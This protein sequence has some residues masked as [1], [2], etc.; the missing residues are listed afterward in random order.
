[1]TAGGAV[2]P[3]RAIRFLVD[4]AAADNGLPSRTFYQRTLRVLD[5]FERMGQR[6]RG[7]A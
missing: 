2:E 4:A 1:M 7:A 3:L 5:I 6:Q